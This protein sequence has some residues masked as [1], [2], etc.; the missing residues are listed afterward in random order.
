MCCTLGSF[1]KA[2][3][4]HLPATFRCGGD[5]VPLASVAVW[6][7]ASP[8]TVD[9]ASGFEDFQHFVRQE[10]LGVSVRQTVSV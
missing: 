9:C 5:E 1:P 8:F 10:R 3:G 4:T 7:G 2:Q 6:C